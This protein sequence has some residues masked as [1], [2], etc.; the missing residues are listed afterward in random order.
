M[1][2]GITASNRKSSDSLVASFI[3]QL[4]PGPARTRNRVNEFRLYWSA[5]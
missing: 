3:F 2:E 4:L 5:R 1:A